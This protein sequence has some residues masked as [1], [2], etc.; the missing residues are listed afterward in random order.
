MGH[1]RWSLLIYLHEFRA[2]GARKMGMQ[3]RQKKEKE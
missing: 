3:R 2:L 1:D